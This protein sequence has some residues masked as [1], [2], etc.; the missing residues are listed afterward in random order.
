LALKA[1][2]FQAARNGPIPNEPKQHD[3]VG[4]YKIAI[5][6]GLSDER[7]IA[8]NLGFLNELHKTHFMRYPAPPSRPVPNPEAIADQTVD[9]LIFAITQ[10]VNPR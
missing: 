3:L 10:V 7:G 8:E 6:Y 2:A 5:G 9:H 4:W 1:F